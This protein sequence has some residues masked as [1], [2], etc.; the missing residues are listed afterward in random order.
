MHLILFDAERVAVGFHRYVTT[1]RSE[2]VSIVLKHRYYTTL[3]ST[4][5][6]ITTFKM[7]GEP[8]SGN[9]F[10]RA[11]A[12][13]NVPMSELRRRAGVRRRLVG[14]YRLQV[15]PASRRG[16]TDA[17]ALV[18][19]RRGRALFR[20]F[21]YVGTVKWTSAI[22]GV[23]TSSLRRAGG[24]ALVG[25]LSLAAPSLGP[26]AAAPF[27]AVAVLAAFGIDEGPLFELFARPGD[28]RDGRL[29]GLAG[30]SLAAT[31]LALLA[32]V[33]RTPMPLSVFVAAV[34]V[35]SYGNLGSKLVA[36]TSSDPFLQAAGFVVGGF[37]AG[38]VGQAAVA[39]VTGDALV[40]PTFAFLAASGALVAALFRSVLYERDDP[41][42]MLSTGLTLWLLA[43]LVTDVPPVEV[44]AALAVTIALGYVSYALEAASVAGML[45]GV[46]LGLLTI[47]LGGFGWFAV[48]I[49]FFGVGALS[50]KFRYEQKRERGVAEPNEG[51]RGTGNVL[52]NSSVALVAV[53]AFAA[54]N[55]LPVGGTAFQLAF[56]GSLAA[57]MSDTL[58]SEIGG[59]YDEPRLLT[60]FER[61]PPGTDGAVT[62]QGELAGVAG[63][64]L[65]ATIAFALWSLS[66]VETAFVVVG[67]VAGM[68]VDSVLGA[69]VEGEY[70][71]NAT[72]NLLATL[73]G[74]VVTALLSIG[75]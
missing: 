55:H 25:T 9:G 36:E 35:L 56:A 21:R 66:P 19:Q 31:V 67:G 63:A 53:V 29:N 72:V 23:V 14:L 3:Y 46:L 10:E 5:Y 39:N 45:T 44:G 64:A 26:A 37:A 8:V 57:A 69:T 24:F 38:G 6:I 34:L 73:A 27:A 30:F 60:T 17:H 51:A 22:S 49:T 13:R 18:A 59:L 58:S 40:L 4:T 71:G 68:T 32:T 12:D 20:E 2:H 52:G 75:L 1:Y 54:S 33:P 70:L 7:V 28:R 41:L 11:D 74:A 65:V 48:L 50:T 43:V 16:L 62:W 15:R 47:V 61:V 42:V